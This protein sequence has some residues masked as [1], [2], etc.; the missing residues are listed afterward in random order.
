MK[1]VA[2]C[3][4][5][6]LSLFCLLGRAAQLP[7]HRECI[8]RPIVSK[9]IVINHHFDSLDI[10]GPVNVYIDATQPHTSLQIMGDLKRVSAVTYSNKNRTLYLRT[11]PIDQ[12][13]PGER[14]TIRV[15]TSPLQIKR[16]Q[17]NSDASLFGKGLKGSLSLRAQGA[18]KVNLYTDKL[19]LTS[20]YSDGNE[21]V[22]LHNILSSNLTIETHNS[23]KVIIQGIVSLNKVNFTGNGNLAVYW[24]NS[25]YLRVDAHGKGEISLAGAVKTLDA[26]LSQAIRLFA[27]QLRARQGFVKT[28]NQAQASINIR[29]LSA[30]AKDNSV[31]Y[32]SSPINF[33]S[34]H[35]E[36]T[37]LVLNKD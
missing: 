37:G 3:L 24:V 36:G 19:N 35:S 29:T 34:K 17:F 30:F 33:I 14:L 12:S 2:C 26:K 28:E 13:M 10:K 16:I 4:F 23:K 27:Q 1:V 32:Y 6:T 25:P 31:I 22:I 11:K 8:K 9:S 18:G 5:I 21:C 20:L 15:N 7:C